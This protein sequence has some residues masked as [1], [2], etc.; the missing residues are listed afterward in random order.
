MLYVL[1]CKDRPSDGLTRRME[2]RPSHLAYLESLGAKVRAAGGILSDDEKEPRGSLLI[3]EASSLDEAKAIAAA[4]PYAKAEVF[5][6]V[7]IYP[8]RQAAGVKTL[9]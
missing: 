6:S 1:I 9:G 4:D 3:I 8:W 2:T 7:E 5:E